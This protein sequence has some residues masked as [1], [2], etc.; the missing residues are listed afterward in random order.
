M[1][2]IQKFFSARLLLARF[3]SAPRTDDADAD[4]DRAVATVEEVVVEVVK[5]VRP[6]RLLMLV[7]VRAVVAVAFRLSRGT[8]ALSL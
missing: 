6:G 2:F 7:E 3:R 4:D 5:E 8:V 1:R